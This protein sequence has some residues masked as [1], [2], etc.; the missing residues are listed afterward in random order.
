V[1]IATFVL[2]VAMAYFLGS[3]PFGLLIGK[4][5]GKKDIREFGSGKTGTTNVLRTAGR[6]AAAIVAILDVLKGVL[7]VI[8]AGLI[9]GDQSLFIGDF[10]VGSLLARTLAAL[11]AVAG[12]N[13]PF[14]LKFRGGRG[15]APFMGA[16]VA[17][18]PP[19]AILGGELIIVG[20]GLS[21]YVSLGSMI[22]VG[23]ASIILIPLVILG[24]APVEYLTYAAIGA[25]MVIVMHR[26]NIQRLLTGKERRLG[27]KA[28]TPGA[29]AGGKGAL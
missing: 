15:V 27:E 10:P 5:S 28:T 18:Y 20:A 14:Y 2:V 22:G 26:D 11:A 25:I 24:H 1:L 7:A 6:R 19:A 12:H 8:L 16:M 29:P 3:I 13:W 21:R 23:S 17:L 9:I 4:L